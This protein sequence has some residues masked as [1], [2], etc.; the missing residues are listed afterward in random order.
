MAS[1]IKPA[2]IRKPTCFGGAATD[3]RSV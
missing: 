2:I 3:V 1:A